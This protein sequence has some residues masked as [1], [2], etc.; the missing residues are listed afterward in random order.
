[1]KFAREGL[2]LVFALGG[3]TLLSQLLGRW[4]LALFFAIVTIGVAAFFRDPERK[5]PPGE[6]LVV[7]PADGRVVAIDEGCAPGSHPEGEFR[8]VSIFMSPLN[9]HV[10]RVPASGEVLSVRHTPGRFVAAYSDRAPLENERNEVSI[11]DRTGRTFV[12]VQIAGLLARRIICRL[13]PGQ[14]VEQ[15]ARY[16][17][18]MF[19]SRVDVYLPSETRLRVRLGD[20]VRAG[21]D[22]LGELSS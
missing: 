9:V 14:R 3:A 12:F 17:L 10:N 16:G 19:G 20:R 15:G 13:Q 7:S 2:P 18:I 11:R 5:V 6:N 1:M 22:V 21:S 4:E 8:R